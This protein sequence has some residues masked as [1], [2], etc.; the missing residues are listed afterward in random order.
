M[1]RWLS[2][3]LGPTGWW[4]ART[5]FE[6]AVGAILTQNTAWRNVEKSITNIR[7]NNL[8]SARSLAAVPVQRLAPL[9]RPS[10]YFR[11]KSQRLKNFVD[12]LQHEYAGSMAKMAREPADSLREELLGVTGIGPE[13]A[14]SILL[15]ALGK[16]VF[17]VDAYTRRILSRHGIVV[18]EQMDYEELRSFFEENLPCDLTLF[19]EFH[20]LLVIAGSRFCKKNALCNECPLRP[21]MT[22]E[23]IKE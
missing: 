9:I 4:P 7:K 11:L 22:V 5:P 12:F 18:V 15:Y 23:T 3:E 13:T 21:L 19:K 17:V 8:L 10:G 14:D 1:Y 2:D 20:A 16:P 6:V